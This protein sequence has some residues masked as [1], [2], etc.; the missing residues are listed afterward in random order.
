MVI[1]SRRVPRHEHA[2]GGSVGS[3]W[4]SREFTLKPLVMPLKVRKMFPFINALVQEE[5]VR[6]VEG[7]STWSARINAALLGLKVGRRQREA[8]FFMGEEKN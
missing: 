4:A 3:C 2:A 5:G 8:S 7:E 6:G 1:S